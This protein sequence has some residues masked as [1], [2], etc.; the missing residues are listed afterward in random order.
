MQ[1]SISC[2][3]V[4]LKMPIPCADQSVLRGLEIQEFFLI[5]QIVKY[6]LKPK[7]E[8]SLTQDIF[9][10]KAFRKDILLMLSNLL[11]LMGT[12]VVPLTTEE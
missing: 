11:V 10:C 5:E 12:K 4:E 8:S 1:L 2:F 7:N 9:D 6:I 3:P